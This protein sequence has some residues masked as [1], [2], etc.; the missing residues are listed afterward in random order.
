MSLYQ[1][2]YFMEGIFETDYASIANI[3]SKTYNPR[4]IVEFGCGPG[5]LTRELS[6]LNINVTAMD[7]FS[8]PDFSN[9]EN[10]TFS[11]VD[12]NDARALSDFLNGRKFD[13]AIC[14]EVAEH[15][16]NSSS[17]HLVES[18]THSAPVVIFSAAVPGQLGHGHINCQTRGFW[19]ALFTSQNFHLA[20]S[21][22]KHL[23]NNESMALWY[24]LNL[25]DYVAVNH[26]KSISPDQTIA[27]LIESE[28][29]SSSCFYKMNNE[30]AKNAAYLNYPLVKQYFQ[31]RKLIKRVAKR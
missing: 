30:N 25:L 9:F 24:K 23:R 26:N 3:I 20:D 29:Y 15:L 22:R 31:L 21:I 12:L 10:I 1:Q 4:T 27:N 17:D 16:E 5:H 13:L 6:K 18:L 28:S 8:H 19:H 2:E 14:T 7:G 11:K